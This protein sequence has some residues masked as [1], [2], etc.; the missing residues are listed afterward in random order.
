MPPGRARDDATCAANLTRCP[1][2][3]MPMSRPSLC[4]IFE[5]VT[6]HSAIAKIALAGVRAALKAGWRVTVAAIEIDDEIRGS[7]EWIRFGGPSRGFA[8]K[9]LTARHFIRWALGNRR[10]D[11]IHAHQPQVA[12]LADIFQ[13]HYLTRVAQEQRC[14]EQGSGMSGLI[15]RAQHYAVLPAEDVC[16]RRWN[17]RTH[18]LFNSEMT[19]R[20][21]GRLYGMP[22]SEEVLVYPFPPL[23]FASEEE[24]ANA[25]A[26]LAPDLRRPIVGYLGGIQERKG[27]R[28]LINGL[29]SSNGGAGPSTSGLDSQPSLL[30]GGSYADGFKAPALGDRFRSVGMVYDTDTFY[31]ACD[32]MVVPSY[33]EPLGLV[34][35]EAAAR[36]VPVVATDGVGALRHLE[37]FGAGVRWDPRIPL[38]PLV[39][40]VVARSASFRKGAVRM[41]EALGVSSYGRLLMGA[42]ERVLQRK[43]SRLSASSAAVV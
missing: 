15:R 28:R 23:R 40:D 6:N 8:L 7:V 11:V 2:A 16:F 18:M 1:I 21:F 24:R 34:A 31:A 30:L 41:A 19:R 4:M 22:P 25:R 26:T 10:F 27:Y 17:P 5:S 32:V 38:G 29:V 42:Y 37:D 36:G 33:F 9:W 43:R 35:F 13:C 39:H 3:R 12:D 20:C 14:I